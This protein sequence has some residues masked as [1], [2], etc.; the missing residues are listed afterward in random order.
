MKDI[1]KEMKSHLA[2]NGDIISYN[3]LY[4]L[5]LYQIELL[6]DEVDKVQQNSFMEEL[7]GDELIDSIMYLE[8]KRNEWLWLL[9]ILDDR[10]EIITF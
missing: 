7:E 1:E 6:N 2:P 5:V 3:K 4:N 8:I 10:Y 9:D